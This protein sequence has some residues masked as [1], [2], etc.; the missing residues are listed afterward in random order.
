MPETDSTTNGG[1]SRT[2]SGV[3]PAVSVVMPTHN[4]ADA[5]GLT[6][7]QLAL[8]T[9]LQGEF[10]VIV[11]DDGS[12]DDTEN[13]VRGVLRPFELR[14]VKQA[15]R[16]AAA[17]RNAGVAQARAPIILFLDSD[18]VPD[19]G[20]L[21]AHVETHTQASDQLIIG[22]VKTWPATPVP[23][24]ERVAQQGSSG[25]DYGDAARLV[26]FA[27]ALGGNFSIQRRVF[28]Q[29]GGYDETFPA[30]G[31]EETEFAYRAE[32]QGYAL[33]YQPAAVGYH[34][35]ARTLAQ[36]C[37]QQESHMRSMALLI[38]LHP[39]TQTTIH[40]VDDLAPILADPGTPRA[41]WR[42]LYASVLGSLPV[43]SGMYRSLTWL[44]RRHASPRLASFLYWRLMTGWRQAGFRDGLRLYGGATRKAT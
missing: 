28:L 20:L 43:R 31:C 41:R 22:R 14:Y 23:W 17:A 21:R 34:N 33:F 29:I 3:R 2:S 30:A 44:D 27:Y 39:E 15:C 1:L 16:G 18:V 9:G 35:H 36:R 38:L 10:E 40:D 26:T 7:D 13:A 19:P 12:T 4:R 25:M 11:V 8:Q 32:Q 42:R 37:K 24:C 6:L 5:I